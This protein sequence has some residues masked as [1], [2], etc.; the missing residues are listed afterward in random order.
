MDRLLFSLMIVQLI[1]SGIAAI[2]FYRCI[3][4]QNISKSLPSLESKKELE[5]LKK[6][7]GISLTKPLAE[8]TRPQ[9]LSAIIGQ[10]QGVKAL[11]AALCGPNPQHILIYGPPGV[12][13]TAAARLI[14]EE[15]KKTDGCPFGKY[16][17]FIE[18]DATTL[19]FDER[20]IADPL[21]GSVHDPI[22]QGAGAFGS[23]GIP[24]PKP[25]AVTQA[26]GGV[27]FI[28]EI[29]EMHPL[30]MNKLLKVLEDR[31][32]RFQSSYYNASNRNIP[33]YIH[34]IFQKGLP[35]DFR[36]IGATTRRPEELPPALR[37]RC[38]EIYFDG[39]KEESLSTIAE[40]SV[41]QVGF[42][43]EKKLLKK[44]ASF[45][46]NG[47]EIVNMVQMAASVAVMEKRTEIKEMDLDWVLEVG[48]YQPLPSDKIAEQAEIG[49]VNGLAVYG[50]DC[51]RL[52]KIEARVHKTIGGRGGS[53][54]VTG[55]VEEE[56]MKASQGVMRRKSNAK[57]SVENV[58]TAMEAFTGL[59]MKD[60]DVH[61]NFPGGMPVDGPSAGTALFCAVYSALYSKKICNTVAMT[62]E[63]SLLGHVLPV[64]GVSIKIEA[65]MQAGVQ[66]VFIPAEN[67]RD[68]YAAL[69]IE[70]IKVSK[71][72]EILEH[73][74]QDIQNNTKLTEENRFGEK[75]GILTAK[76][77]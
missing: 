43:C 57:S 11:R 44:M 5:N 64:G 74:Y 25:G 32:A 50:A 20:S 34:E 21:V 33:D 62:G 53:L 31:V 35:A 10:E 12:G 18:L 14:L 28:D 68:S 76:G 41:V 70:V 1:F 37:S 27:L 71:V 4:G 58:M 51:G 38:M 8:Q 6:L 48:R 66:R 46:S 7:R 77:I 26:H 2:Y 15:A 42:Y 61:I 24:Q 75:E 63:I 19:R 59:S 13:K 36:L 3:K 47:R 49:V 30:Q 16:S 22:Y 60:Y 55:I 45:A 40:N 73:L 54:T 52:L 65:A 67:W 56:E 9:T 72:G 29:G 23:A 17:K 39:L 69:G